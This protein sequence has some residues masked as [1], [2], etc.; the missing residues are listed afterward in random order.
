[1]VECHLCQKTFN[2]KRKLSVCFK[3]VHE[4]KYTKKSPLSQKMLINKAGLGKHIWSVHKHKKPLQCKLCR[5][6]FAEIRGLKNR[7]INVHGEKHPIERKK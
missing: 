2:I 1:M 5:K 6:S 7:T 4:K 3:I